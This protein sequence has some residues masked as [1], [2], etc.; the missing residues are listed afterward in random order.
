MP[1][2]VRVFDVYVDG[3]SY[4]EVRDAA[5][6]SPYS[7]VKL[8][9]AMS[10]DN[11]LS[12][13]VVKEEDIVDAAK[14]EPKDR[15]L[16]VQMAPNEDYD[17]HDPLQK[18]DIYFNYASDSCPNTSSASL[19]SNAESSLGDCSSPYSDYVDISHRQYTR[20][21]SYDLDI[22]TVWDKKYGGDLEDLRESVKQ[23][24]MCFDDTTASTPALEKHPDS[25]CSGDPSSLEKDLPFS[26]ENAEVEG[27]NLVPSNANSDIVGSYYESDDDTA[28]LEHKLHLPLHQFENSLEV[29][30][31]SLSH[32]VENA[33]NHNS[34][35]KEHLAEHDSSL[36]SSEK[37]LLSNK[38]I[39]SCRKDNS[40]A[41]EQGHVES[42]VD[43]TN[44][45]VPG[46]KAMII[47]QKDVLPPTEFS[48][49]ECSVIDLDYEDPHGVDSN[50]VIITQG[51]ADQGQRKSMD[52]N[53]ALHSFLV[54]KNF[55]DVPSIRTNQEDIED[56]AMEKHETVHEGNS[57]KHNEVCISL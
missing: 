41:T 36:V 38:E 26:L 28:L 57:R 37:D 8:A 34:I 31:S 53:S 2:G 44:N 33:C 9:E 6:L 56:Y 10:S 23:F 19:T 48:T 17:N 20:T 43:L 55:A 54:E 52:H 14:D 7:F 22:D 30:N 5:N 24:N 1:Y 40:D 46:D 51:T 49:V 35:T 13:Y 4:Q 3:K 27:R 45:D 15:C 12:R 39:E 50:S 18:A 47:P 21:T 11:A 25:L 29:G 16:E 42:R 32:S